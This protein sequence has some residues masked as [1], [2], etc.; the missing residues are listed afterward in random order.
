MRHLLVTYWLLTG[1]SRNHTENTNLFINTLILKK[2][3]A[4]FT[5][6]SG[7]YIL[8][9]KISYLLYPHS[10]LSKF[11]GLMM[12]IPL[13]G[14]TFLLL[15]I[16]N[17]VYADC[18]DRAGLY[19]NIDPDYLRSIA[20]RESSFN[21]LATNKNKNKN[22]DVLSIDYGIMQINSKT[23][24]SF[25]IEYPQ[26]TVERLISEPCLNIHVGAMVLRRNFNAYGTNWLAVGM[27]NAGVKNR[28]ETISARHNYAKSIYFIYKKI[29]SGNIKPKVIN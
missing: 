25:R 24:N 28:D 17:F 12:P 16:S 20:Y 23:L 29:K 6:A 1:Y 13:A 22:G 27:Y 2:K 19:Y 15:L 10:R 8:L 9:L 4:N 3:H 18:F 26:L 11:K 21:P 7:V 14:A 5:F